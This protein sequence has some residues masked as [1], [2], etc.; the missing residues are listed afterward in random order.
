MKLVLVTDPRNP[1]EVLHEVNLD[2]VPAEGDTIKLWQIN[3]TR[4][5][6]PDVEPKAPTHSLNGKYTVTKAGELEHPEPQLP[7]CSEHSGIYPHIEVRWVGRPERLNDG[8]VAICITDVPQSP[9]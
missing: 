3:P 8:E 5:E 7:I 4:F 2:D 9:T 6:G 1:E